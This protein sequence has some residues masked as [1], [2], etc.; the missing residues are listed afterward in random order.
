MPNHK[1]WFYRSD[2]LRLHGSMRGAPV[3]FCREIGQVE[4]TE[5]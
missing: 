3:L 1:C 5:F 2:M 4:R